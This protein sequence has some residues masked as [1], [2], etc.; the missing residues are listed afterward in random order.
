MRSV[1]ASWARRLITV[2]D[3]TFLLH[4]NRCGFDPPRSGE[5][6]RSGSGVG[7]RGRGEDGDAG[8][9]PVRGAAELD[10]VG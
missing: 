7:S 10:S 5:G 9:D 8:A 4:R 1:T 3:K 2:C 6:V